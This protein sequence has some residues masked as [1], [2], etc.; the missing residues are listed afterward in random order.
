MQACDGREG[1]KVEELKFPEKDARVGL[2]LNAVC[3][4]KNAILA[5]KARRSTR[6]ASTHLEKKHTG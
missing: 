6:A 4:K 5:T 1:T 3:D 2:I